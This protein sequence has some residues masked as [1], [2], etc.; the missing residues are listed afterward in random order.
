[1][2]PPDPAPT[3]ALLLSRSTPL[4]EEV[5]RLAAAADIRPQVAADPV[6]ALPTWST[7]SLV[8]VGADLVAELAQVRPPRRAGVHVVSLG[9]LP[10]LVFR[11]ALAVGAESVAELPGSADWL[12]EL[13]GDVGE[14]PGRVV[15]V[16]G[17]TGGA[18]ATTYAVA[19]AQAAAR[20]GTALLVDTDPLG[21]G[22]D[23][24]LGMEASQG[25]RWESLQRTSGRLASRSLREAVPRR[26]GLGVLTWAAAVP[27]SV[28]AFAAREAL[29]AGRRGHDLVVVDL[30]REG[31]LLG[32][33]AARCDLVA[34]VTPASVAGA[35]SAARVVARLGSVRCG[36]VLRPGS[37]APHSM[38]AAVGVPVLATLPDQRGVTEAAEL[39]C[40]P[41]RSRRGPLARAVGDLL[42]VAAGGQA[43]A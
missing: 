24:M 37:V 4:A 5:G 8:L 41:L 20:A 34:V 31:P 35:A 6:A 39:G 12:V 7:A 9:P 36:L 26:D 30:S 22:T 25:A 21:P 3:A 11:E 14:Q 23:R 40:G 1:M 17:G 43:A 19:L 16:V 38:A 15:G 18:G 2:T 42:A 28:Q 10:D 33:L 29:E 27:G 32:E 13:L